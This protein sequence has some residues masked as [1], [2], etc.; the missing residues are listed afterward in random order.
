MAFVYHDIDCTV[1]CYVDR[2]LGNQ[3]LKDL[4]MPSMLLIYYYDIA[5]MWPSKFVNC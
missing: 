2:S 5:L 3:V 4:V 1:V